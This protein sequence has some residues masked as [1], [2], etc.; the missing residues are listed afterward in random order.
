MKKRLII[1]GIIFACAIAWCV[2]IFRL[3]G[4]NS[5]SSN[6]RSVGLVEQGIVKILE[7]TNEADITHS[8]PDAAKL[9]KA[10]ELVNAPLRKVIHATV[11]F[12]LALFLLAISR[13]LFGEKHYLISCAVVLLLCFAFAIT[14]EYHQTFVDGR[15]GQFLDV[16]IDTAGACIS[17]LVFSSY[18]AIYKLGRRK[19]NFVAHDKHDHAIMEIDSK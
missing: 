14:D 10:A 8:Y 9:A 19:T 1:A 6:D 4:M 16:L 2:V 18:F 15:T 7:I 3:S 11:Y 13:V 17:I 12:V 5:S